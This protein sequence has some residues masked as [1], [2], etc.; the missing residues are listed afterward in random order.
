MEKGE[1][2]RHTQSVGMVMKINANLLHNKLKV[3]PDFAWL[4]LYFIACPSN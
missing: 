2:G 1:A 4:R 3:P